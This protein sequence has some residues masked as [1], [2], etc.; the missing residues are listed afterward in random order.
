MEFDLSWLLL[1]LPLAF[2]LGWGA[3][4][5]DLRQ[6][7]L[8]NK[9]APRS[10]FKGLNYLLNEQQDQAID[11]FIEAVQSDPDTSELHFAL[12]NLFRRRGEFERAVR[13][14]EHLLSRADLSAADRD[15][16][17]H[18]LALDFLKAGLLDRAEVALQRLEGTAFEGAARLALLAIYERSRDWAQAAE[19]AQRMTQAKQGQFANRE[20]HYLCEQA[21]QAAATN[22]EWAL[23][24]LDLAIQKA[25][26]APRA[27]LE[28]AKI[29]DR[30]QQFEAVDLCLTQLARDC[31]GYVPLGVLMWA[32]AAQKIQRQ[33]ALDLCLQKLY[34]ERPSLDLL[35]ARIALL[36]AREPLQALHDT[37]A[38]YEEHL[39]QEP[40]LVAAAGWLKAHAQIAPA[41]GEGDDLPKTLQ[42]ALDRATLPLSRYRCAACGFEAKTYF[43][44]CPGC[45]SWDSFP[46]QRIEEL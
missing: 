25:P 22:P 43:W 20:A 23:D 10:Y 17:Q 19:I 7:R 32:N 42:R 11:A 27:Y 24:Q 2:V 15:R 44:H 37:L 46:P 38:L 40:S 21:L 28:K 9:Q 12:G 16:A 45:Q 1:G 31:P 13:V 33:A 41:K 4:R 29:L 39:N 3:S 18:A 5:F 36:N 6:W 26:Q 34:A 14:H 8:E 35:E 30:Q